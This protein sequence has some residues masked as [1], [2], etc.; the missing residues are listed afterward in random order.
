M[1][2][3]GGVWLDR[4][5]QNTKT[6][7]DSGTHRMDFQS[8]GIRVEGGNND[9]VINASA[10]NLKGTT[11]DFAN[12]YT[13]ILVRN[14]AAGTDSEKTPVSISFNAP[15]L[16][17]GTGLALDILP[18][19]GYNDKKRYIGYIEPVLHFNQGLTISHSTGGITLDDR[20]DLNST[21]LPSTG[22]FLMYLGWGS[23]VHATDITL[24]HNTAE[25]A[26]R[27]YGIIEVTGT[28]SIR[29]LTGIIGIAVR[30]IKAKNIE[31][32]TLNNTTP[33][34]LAY[35][36]GAGGAHYVDIDRMDIRNITG[37]SDTSGFFVEEQ[38]DISVGSLTVDG[39]TS[40]GASASGLALYTERSTLG[41][42]NKLTFSSVQVA[43]VKGVTR[44]DGVILEDFSEEYWRDNGSSMVHYYPVPASFGSLSVKGVTA[45]GEN[46]KARGLYLNSIA[47]PVSVGDLSVADISSE[48]ANGA[49]NG[50][51]IRSATLNITGNA[52]ITIDESVSGDYKGA[53]SGAPSN[54]GLNIRSA[55][56]RVVQAGSVAFSGEGT[57]RISGTILVGGDAGTES[58]PASLSFSGGTTQIAGDIYVANGGQLTLEASGSDS[59]I[60]GQIDD[61]HD[62]G[63][64]ASAARSVSFLTSPGIFYGSG[65]MVPASTAGSAS[66]SLSK[67][68]A[69][70]A[71]GRS[72]VKSLAFGEGG[73]TVDLSK[74]EGASFT[75]GS[76]SGSGTFVMRASPTPSRGS[77]LYTTD[78]QKGSSNTIALVV[79][80]SE[81]P[82]IE[83]LKGVR[84]ATTNGKAAGWGNEFKAEMKDQGVT[85]V[86]F[87]LAKSDYVKG[88]ASNALYNGE[89]SGEGT[90][91]PGVA[92]TDAAFGEEGTNWYIAEATE[93][94]PVTPDTPETPDTPDT[95]D[96]PA[97]PDQ[98]VAPVQPDNGGQTPE[99]PKV[100]LSDAGRAVLGAAR[101]LYWNAVDMDRL[102]KRLGEARHAKGDDGLWLRI[103]YDNLESS[104]GRGDFKSSAATYQAGFDRAFSFSAGRALAG[105]AL[106]WR[107]ADDDFK[108]LSGDGDTR[109][110]GVKAYGTWLGVSGAY[111]DLVAQWGRL[112]NSFN[113]VNG[114]GGR[115][116][117]DFDNHVLGFSAEAGHKLPL[118]AEGWFV[119]PELQ[120]QY[121]HVTDGNYSTTQGSR[122]AQDSFNSVLSRAG[123]RA[124]R[125]FGAE[126]A[127]SFYFK[128]DWI[129]E[130]SG[131]QKIRAF[132]STTRASG[133]DASIE[134]K[135]SW[136]DAGA[137]FQVALGRSAFAFAD[138]EYRFGNSLE[139]AWSVNA[140][141]RLSF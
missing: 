80:R 108:G 46:G 107:H 66:V 2:P 38:P 111:V 39:I 29:D 131:K 5:S 54:D 11:G 115:V 45:T 130:W 127:S 67:G 14:T 76:L 87:S 134:N 31:V 63:G 106:D 119:E 128:A 110:F 25:T 17:E 68:A 120:L 93:T 72:F 113:I 15:V 44:A 24:E 74:S 60:R 102:V 133:Y 22:T 140:G 94:K 96:T 47:L 55:A 21:P 121:L 65:S 52:D 19:P 40:T 35:G 99:K 13:G 16:F 139:S 124:G 79:D 32:D 48:G 88:D 61:Y 49:A 85:N 90:Y 58:T 92:F 23:E 83:A 43:N 116:K 84:L 33:T 103:R 6:T 28:L 30:D 20:R 141:V 12:P 50:V 8:T 117:G 100:E 136:Y 4:Q 9:L 137:G 7:L 89:G 95:P 123:F 91:R 126:K 62:L 59:F 1:L 77:M 3:Y 56:I 27:S 104:S 73:G 129:R 37:V 78:L 36:V 64:E 97:T 42:S 138:A 10:V 98:P 135:G 75:A 57:R 109:R 26:I 132:D 82:N 69:W 18:N 81:V 53:F 118:G 125:S 71:Y 114:S 112:A 70:T 122:I 101:S 86:T 51:Q 41:D 34:M 105:L